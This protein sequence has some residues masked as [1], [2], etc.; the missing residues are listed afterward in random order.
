MRFAFLPFVL[1]SL[2][3]LAACQKK[4]EPQEEP[5]V[6][7]TNLPAPIVCD[8]AST[9]NALIKALSVELTAAV[10]RS[11]QAYA[12][13]ETLEIGRRAMQ[14]LSELQLDLQE[15]QAQ[16]DTCRTKVVVSLPVVDATHAERYYRSLGS[17][18]QEHL[19]AKAVGL[20]D[21]ALDFVVDYT[22]Q[23][24][25]V[26]L[27]QGH[28]ALAALADT[29]TASAYG[30]AKS[31]RVKVAVQPAITVQTLEPTI[32]VPAT[33]LSSLEQ[34]EQSQSEPHQDTASETV[35]EHT[36]NHADVHADNHAMPP[37]AFGDDQITI[38]ET[39]ET[40]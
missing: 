16:G 15:V 28:G 18:L 13:G 39:N 31:E 11:A 37:T 27:E 33:D 2:L 23:K 38:V 1:V 21:N 36:D 8:D 6:E 14:R 35:H 10:N 17:S 32:I 3:A 24:N 9:K 25:S 5:V 29:M 40:Y 22:P 30:L 34:T 12:D 7:Q 4:P 20:M 19:S 26:Q